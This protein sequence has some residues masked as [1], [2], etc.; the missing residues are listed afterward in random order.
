MTKSGR[1][2]RIWLGALAVFAGLWLLVAFG[3]VALAEPLAALLAAGS[4]LGNVYTWRRFRERRTSAMAGL[5]VACTLVD[6]GLVAGAGWLGYIYYA[7]SHSSW[8]WMG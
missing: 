4:A 1:G 2:T 6:L 5:A 8:S 3:M 7:L